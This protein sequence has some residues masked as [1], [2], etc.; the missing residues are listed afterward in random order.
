MADAYW[1][2]CAVLAAI[3]FIAGERYAFKHPDRQNT[4]SQSIYNLGSKFPLAIFIMGMFCGGLAVHFFW[5]W[6]P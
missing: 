3:L 5:R 1:I 2:A 4:L 6:C